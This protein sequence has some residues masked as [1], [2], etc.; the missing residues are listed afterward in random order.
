MNP[1]IFELFLGMIKRGPVLEIGLRHSALEYLRTRFDVE[2]F[3]IGTSRFKYDMD[4]TI[5]QNMFVKLPFEKNEFGGGVFNKTMNLVGDRGYF[6]KEIFRVTNGPVLLYDVSLE[7][8][9]ME[10][11][12]EKDNLFVEFLSVDGRV[13]E[14][15]QSA[16]AFSLRQDLNRLFYR[17]G[18]VLS[19]FNMLVP[20]D[21]KTECGILIKKIE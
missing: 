8:F 19:K 1:D 16:M 5:K 12:E 20:Q 13:V 10:Y 7:S 11:F 14:I 4:S 15:N 9:P 18:G 21:I 3:D 17:P 6:L 2:S